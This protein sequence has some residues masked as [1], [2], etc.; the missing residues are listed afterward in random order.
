MSRRWVDGWERV[1]QNDAQQRA[2]DFKMAVVVDKTQ[3]AKFVHE[4]AYARPRRAD[5]FSE[6]FL[7]DLRGDRIRPTFLAEVGQQ[8]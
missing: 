3:V 6:C 7:T 1:G 4:I 5:H 2:V 8:Q